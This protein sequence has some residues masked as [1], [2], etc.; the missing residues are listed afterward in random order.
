[1]VMD[2][3]AVLQHD[4]QHP[5]Q[6]ITIT[7]TEMSPINEADKLTRLDVTCILDTAEQVD[8]KNGTLASILRQPTRW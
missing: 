5:I 2:Q 7:Q 3:N 1:M 6:D 8:I 4:L